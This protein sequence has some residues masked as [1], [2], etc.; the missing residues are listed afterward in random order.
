MHLSLLHPVI[1]HALQEIAKLAVTQDAPH[2][3]RQDR[4]YKLAILKHRL[5]NSAGLV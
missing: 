5:R 3:F 2:E 4:P 1:Y